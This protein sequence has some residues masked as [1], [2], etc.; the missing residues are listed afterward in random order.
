MFP[1][2]VKF[3]PKR[4]VVSID[5]VAVYVEEYTLS[6]HPVELRVKLEFDI[7]AFA[8]SPLE[9][10]KQ[11]VHTPPTR[12]AMNVFTPGCNPPLY[13]AAYT[14]SLQLHTLAESVI[15]VMP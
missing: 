4:F 11:P 7:I 12:D 6:I 10:L 13:K 14:S 15:M 1:H 2:C 3:I 8:K 5:A 9:S